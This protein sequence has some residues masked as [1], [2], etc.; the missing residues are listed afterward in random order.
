MLLLRIL[1]HAVTQ[2]LAI[3]TLF[4]TIENIYMF[5]TWST[6]RWEKMREA[7]K[8]SVKRESETRWSVRVVAVK[9]IHDDINDLV[10]LLERLSLVR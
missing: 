3:V 10:D 1:R 7:L 5:F 2:D 4:G 8:I 9:A 6:L